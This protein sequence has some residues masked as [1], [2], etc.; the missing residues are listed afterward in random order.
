MSLSVINEDLSK[1]I[2]NF[3][4]FIVE[5]KI[6]IIC[7]FIF[8][9]I[10]FGFM[11]TNHSLTIDEE[12]WIN[13]NATSN[14]WLWLVQGRF[15]IFLI[16]KVISPT[17]NYI[18]FL[19]DF[20]SVV[21]WNF[22]GVCFLF[23]ISMVYTKFN[24]FSSFVFCAYFSSLPLV[25]GEIL[26]YSMFNLQQSLGMLFMAISVLCIYT[27][28]KVKH[29]KYIIISW[30]LL[31]SSISIYQAFTVVY[32]VMIIAY[33]LFFVLK[34]DYIHTKQVIHNITKALLVLICSVLTY[35]LIN[36]II[37]TY[38]APD[39]G[40]YLSGYIGWN[41]R[42]NNIHVI[43]TTL[44]YVEKILFGDSAVY[45]GKVILVVTCLFL[46]Y[47]IFSFIN[48]KKIIEKSMICILSILLL[49]SPFTLSMVLGTSGINGRTYLALPLAGAIQLL[50][51]NNQMIKIRII[52]PVVTIVTVFL[53]LLN[54]MYMNRLFYNSFMVY[55]FD[56]NVGNEIIHD[57]GVDGY[58]Y[59]NTPLV[60]LGMHDVDRKIFSSN[61]GSTGG[62]FFSWD[63]GNN[64]RIINL[65]KSEGYDVIMPSTSQIKYSYDNSNDLKNWPS[66]YSIKE[67][68]GCIVIKLSKP[69]P[70]WISVNG[71]K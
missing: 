33:S 15:G 70:T 60:F 69:S 7:S 56:S 61:S 5:Y 4:E 53:L 32:I 9:L 26:S 54:S 41:K 51:V 68:N 43:L 62:S 42:G 37:T 48:A 39:P 8:T 49:I 71:V 67:I 45:G 47:S 52:K 44:H 23:C 10:C 36:K 31:F 55:Q 59:S 38:I 6:P 40:N 58:N 3:K 14:T 34:H 50:L 2:K 13:S 19:W 29:N 20:L 22:S 25:V 28:F 18:P 64:A 17:G 16:D 35:Y 66:R 11:L 21:I 24:K 63:D 1:Q 27:Y 65:L 30:V 46:V 12:T 57:I